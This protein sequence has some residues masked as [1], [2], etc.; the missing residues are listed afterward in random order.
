VAGAMLHE[1]RPMSRAQRNFALICAEQ[2]PGFQG[3]CLCE[4]LHTVKTHS[5]AELV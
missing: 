1:M 4:L 2:P 3:N 5:Q